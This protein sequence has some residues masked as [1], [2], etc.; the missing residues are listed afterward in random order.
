MNNNIAPMGFGWAW[1]WAPDVGLWWTSLASMALDIVGDFNTKNNVEHYISAVIDSSNW[2]SQI[3]KIVVL[4]FR[5]RVE[6]Q[7]M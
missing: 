5:N 7:E 4:S 2:K 3:T 6:M 1:V